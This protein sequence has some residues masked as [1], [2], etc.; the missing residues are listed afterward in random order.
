MGF[1]GFGLGG[2]FSK[3]YGENSLESAL[4]MLAEIPEELPVH[5]LGVGEPG[6][7]LLAIEHGADLFDCV[8]ATRIGRHGSIYTKRGIIHLKNGEYKNDFTPLDPETPIAG[9][10]GF[11]RAYAS[12]LVRSGELTGS[13]ICSI[14]NVGFILALVRG[15]R[16]AILNGTFKEYREG[17]VR[18]YY[19][20]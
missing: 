6:D 5:G 17:F 16:E 3:K 4:A 7:I 8:A 1:D 19:N 2:S 18:N 12:H 9:V 15:A 11:T 13:L 14:H 20:K 10:E